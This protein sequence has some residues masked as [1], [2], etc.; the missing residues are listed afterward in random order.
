MVY[1]E[2]QSLTAKLVGTE[3]RDKLMITSNVNEF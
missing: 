1:I 3:R 2:K